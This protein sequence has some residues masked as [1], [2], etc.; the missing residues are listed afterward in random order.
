MTLFIGS[1]KTSETNQLTVLKVKIGI[2][3]AV[4]SD[5]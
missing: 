4:S 1:S 2:T 5:C 3:L